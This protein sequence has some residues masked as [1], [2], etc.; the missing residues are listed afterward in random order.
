[1]SPRQI[2]F[3]AKDADGSSTRY[4]AGQYRAALSAAGWLATIRVVGSGGES[5]PAILRAARQAEV[6]VVLRKT[7]GAIPT[8]LLRRAAHRLVFDFDDAIFLASNGTASRTRYSRFARLLRTCDQVWAGN[9]YLAAEAARHCAR[10]TVLPTAVDETR[11]RLP[12]PPEHEP[13][14]VDLVWIGSRST[15]KYLRTIT[16]VLDQLAGE[17]PQLRLKIVADFDLPA[18]RINRQAIAWSEASE[19]AELASAQIG[20]A[21]MIDNPWARGKCG[22]KVL[23]YMAAGLPV[24]TD[25][26]GV[27][28]EMVED[29]VTGF[30]VRGHQQ[31]VEAITTL[32]KDAELRRRFGAAGRQRLLDRGYALTATSARMLDCLARLMNDSG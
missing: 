10:V 26:V 29:G 6:V 8:W 15:G 12:G 2:L 30:L 32:A 31:W 4:R 21:P 1:M 28:T 27:N 14:T 25:A 18:L 7:F 16:G 9:E 13:A 11:Y 19:A 3:L 24:I 17:L 22:L 23:Q 20:I 5:W